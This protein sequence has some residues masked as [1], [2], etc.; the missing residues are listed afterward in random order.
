MVM[1]H[2]RAFFIYGLI[3]NF[4]ALG[5]AQ[6]ASA[7]M[8]STQTAM[9]MQERQTRISDIQQQLAR[10]DIQQQMMA[11]GVDPQLAQER[12][13]ALTDAEL[14]QLDQQLGNLPAGGSLVGVIGVVFVV[15][16]ILELLGVTDVFTRI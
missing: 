7:A 16:L 3:V 5:F 1:N 8:I 11:L 13:A 6:T 2:L 10:E 9:A 15:L 4:L 14:Q 12:I